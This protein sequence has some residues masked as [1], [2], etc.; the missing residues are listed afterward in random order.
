MVR[1]LGGAPCLTI[2]H[3][4]G[5]VGSIRAN[6]LKYLGIGTAQ[7]NCQTPASFVGFSATAGDALNAG[8][9]HRSSKSI[10]QYRMPWL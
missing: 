5:I 1:Y 10:S 9:T 4:G 7:P 2:K 6:A 8:H 3:H